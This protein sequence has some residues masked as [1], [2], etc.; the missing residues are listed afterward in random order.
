M[1]RAEAAARVEAQ[2]TLRRTPLKRKTRLVAKSALKAK[3]P[4]ARRSQLKATSSLAGGSTLKRAAMKRKPRR[5]KP[6][7]DKPYKAWIKTLPCVVGGPACGKVDPHH[8]IDGK[9][10]EKKGVG[11]TAPDRL[12]LPLC[13]AHHDQFHDRKGFCRYWD[14]EKRHTFQQQEVERLREIWRDLNELEVLQEPARKAI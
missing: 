1:E 12:L 7:D 5:A 2:V 9:G 4:L 14:R 3:K 10:D 11:Q 6:G 8:L 13:R